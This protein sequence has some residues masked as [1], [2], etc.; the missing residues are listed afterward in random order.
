[1]A[2]LVKLDKLIAEKALAQAWGLDPKQ[3]RYCL[4]EQGAPFYLL[5]RGTA[6]YDGDE[7]YDWIVARCRRVRDLA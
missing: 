5:K 1:M 6:L 4:R 7:L 3:V 2:D